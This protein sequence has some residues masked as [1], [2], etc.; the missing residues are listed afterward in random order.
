[1]AV[2]TSAFF[3]FNFLSRGLYSR[4]WLDKKH[5][6]SLATKGKN[7]IPEYSEVMYGKED[8]AHLLEVYSSQVDRVIEVSKH[9]LSGQQ[10]N[11]SVLKKS[12]II[13]DALNVYMNQLE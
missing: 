6:R 10:G 5:N 11:A 4:R 3:I 2:L 1:M 13:R 8:V 7:S 9:K 12:V